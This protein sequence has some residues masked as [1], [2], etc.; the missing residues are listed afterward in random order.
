VSTEGVPPLTGDRSSLDA[1]ARAFGS[2]V[3]RA[4]LG[5]G[6]FG[7]IF[8]AEDPASGR[9]AVVRTFQ[10]PFSSDQRAALLEALEALCLRPLDHPSIAEPLASGLAGDDVYVVHAYV[11]GT[12]ID[13]FFATHGAPA[14]ADLLPR[15]TRAAA[16]IDYAAAAGVHHGALSAKD[17]IVGADHTAIA[18]F[19][20]L[21]ALVVSGVTSEVPTRADDIRALAVIALEVL[22]G[23]EFPQIDVAAA[24]TAFPG[25]VPGR[26]LEAFEAALSP[27]PAVRPATAL[28]FAARLQAA[29]IEAPPAVKEP[30]ADPAPVPAALMPERP[31]RGGRYDDDIDIPLRPEATIR[32]DAISSDVD[33]DDRAHLADRAD[34]REGDERSG[35]QFEMG[36]D[37][38]GDLHGSPL[39]AADD[40]DDGRA[41]PLRPQASIE[42]VAATTLIAARRRSSALPL[43]MAALL[44][45]L[46]AGFG[47]GYIVGWRSAAGAPAAVTNDPAASATSGVTEAPL[48]PPEPVPSASLPAADLPIAVA[49]P[50]VTVPPAATAPAV[51]AAPSR[52]APAPGA[53]PVAAPT[54]RPAPARPASGNGSLLVESRPVGAVVRVDG[55]VV[56]RTPLVVGEVSAGTHR[57]VLEMAGFQPWAT[58]V[59]VDGGT[60]TRVAASLEQ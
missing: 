54:E 20:L 6:R 8:L 14:V 4:D 55:T 53:P 23:A 12:T 19:G 9:Q 50:A 58:S 57:V 13:A 42:D 52:G 43:A 47:G 51:P 7:P 25:V 59:A 31:F 17:V 56:G 36:R 24:V 33:L 22:C 5:F 39:Q 44:I 28:D 26:L 27:Y 38:L 21:Q 60:R 3:V 32:R 46:S 41:V 35:L 30:A 40:R 34:L 11:P 29:T 2:Y 48:N 45:G 18:G 15:L 16:A 1:P 49:P 37:T 10:R